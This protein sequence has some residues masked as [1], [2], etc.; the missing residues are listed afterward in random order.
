MTQ[1]FLAESDVL[2]VGAGIVGL[3]HAAAALRRGRTVTVIDRDSRA[4]GASIRNFGHACVT[5]QSGD[6]LDLAHVARGRWLDLAGAAGF[7][8]VQH[9]AVAVARTATELAVLDELAAGREQGEVRLLDAAA[10]RDALSAP[11]D[12][13]IAGGALLRDDLRVDPRQAVG[14]I[15]GWLSEQGVRF[16]WNTSYLEAGDGVVQ[17][18]RGTIRAERTYVCVGHDLD[19][20]HPAEAAEHGIRRCGLQMAR[21]AAPDGVTIAPAV[22]TGTSMLRYPAFAE[23]A[24]AET[25]RAEFLASDPAV[26]DIDANVMFTQ[27]PDGTII[28][29]D[30]H[31]YEATMDPFLDE[32]TSDLL[33]ARVAEVLGAGPLRVVERWQGVYAHSLTGPYLVREVAD[34]V[35]AV[36]VTSG[37]G[38]TIA[39]GLAERVLDRPSFSTS[40]PSPALHSLTKA[41]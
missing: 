6:L 31:R 22:L 30:S 1:P 34:G 36:S 2:V 19:Y 26:I 11:G 35:T 33:L 18:S 12:A 29:G 15:A 24:A 3:A 40:V 10:V 38:M 8:A 37:V 27:R 14:S 9:G 25:L 39:L 5:A 13:R 21:V 23:T 32:A 41:N 4:V 20:V 28:V 17:T 7:F 16:L